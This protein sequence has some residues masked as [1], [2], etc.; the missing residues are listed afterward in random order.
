MLSGQLPKR[1]NTDQQTSKPTDN[2][3]CC[4]SAP[5]VDLTSDKEESAQ[6]APARDIRTTEKASMLFNAAS[7]KLEASEE[8][9]KPEDTL[10]II[11]Y[12]IGKDCSDCM[13]TIKAFQTCSQQVEQISKETSFRHK[14]DGST[15]IP[16][17]RHTS[18]RH[19]HQ[20]ETNIRSNYTTS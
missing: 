16:K 3:I 4:T 15:C 13:G 8:D 1:R 7:Q 12:L 6:L 14:I 17:I 20:Y 19:S 2:G 5:F 9:I 11:N 10:D 18:G